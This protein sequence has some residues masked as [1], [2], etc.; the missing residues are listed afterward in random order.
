MILYSCTEEINLSSNAMSCLVDTQR[1]KR[2]SPSRAVGVWDCM[3]GETICCH[4]TSEGLPRRT[5][6]TTLYY[7]ILYYTLLAQPCSSGRVKH[8]M[9]FQLMLEGVLY[10][11]VIE[12]SYISQARIRGK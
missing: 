6:E 4:V 1:N 3:E 2:S 8:N 11:L 7:T 5:M 12:T 9:H 10:E